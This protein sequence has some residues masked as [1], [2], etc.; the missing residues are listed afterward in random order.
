MR[1]LMRP[2]AP[3]IVAI[4]LVVASACSSSSTS[5]PAATTVP[6]T[7]RAT[8]TTSTT[9]PL[10][11]AGTTYGVGRR[12]ITLVD[13]TRGTDTDARDDTPAKDDRT[14][15][16]VLLYPTTSPDDDGTDDAHPV[17]PGRFPLVVFSHGVT[18][19]GPAYVG[20]LRGLAA[21]GYVVALPT[22]PLTSGGGAW[23]NLG[24][25]VNQPGDVSFVITELLAR[26]ADGDEL[27]GDHLSPDAIGVAG[28]SLGA[29][30]SLLF[31]NSCCRDDR[32]DAVLAVSGLLFPAK[33]PT[34]DYDDPPATP[35]LL[36]HGEQDGTVPYDSSVT[37]FDTFTDVPRAFVTLPDADH[38]G[39]LVSPSFG[40]TVIA[41]FD[42]ELRHDPTAWHGVQGVW[43]DNGDGTIQ[44]AGGMPAP[45]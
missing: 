8:S 16:T 3:I 40:A 12:D 13:T 19:S 15:E 43:D 26:S 27:L 24:E 29:I 14:L 25:V 17:A 18:A 31:F 30:T 32:V 21:A 9:V 28:H 34:D 22:F 23:N 44:V 38:T 11:P 7:S 33:D 36:I 39:P 4:L 35:L 1:R 2:V 5:S 6:A 37:V 45:S 10:T 42:L 41:F 20:V